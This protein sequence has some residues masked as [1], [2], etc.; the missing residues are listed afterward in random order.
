MGKELTP[1]ALRVYLA[2]LM[3][4]PPAKLVPAFVRAVQECKYFPSPAELLDFAGRVRNDSTPETEARGALLSLV[5]HMREFGWKLQDKLGAIKNDGMDAQC[6][7]MQ[8]PEREPS[9]PAPVLPE[10]TEAALYVMGNGNRMLGL[11]MLRPY[12]HPIGEQEARLIDR[13]WVESYA[14]GLKQGKVLA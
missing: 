13:R 11:E 9:T 2:A 7:V 1:E 8:V 10:A 4:Y 6:R 3:P 14:L 12:L 5:G